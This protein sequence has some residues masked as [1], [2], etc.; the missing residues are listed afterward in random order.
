M[1]QKGRWIW[2]CMGLDRIPAGHDNAG[3]LAPGDSAVAIFG[4]KKMKVF[5]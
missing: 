5:K 2:K 1:G 3:Y 4:C